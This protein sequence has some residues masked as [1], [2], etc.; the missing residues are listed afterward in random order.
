MLKNSDVIGLTRNVKKL[1]S[2]HMIYSAFLLVSSTFSSVTSSTFTYTCHKR[3]ALHFHPHADWHSRSVLSLD[4][5]LHLSV[6]CV[7]P[8]FF[9][10]H[11]VYNSRNL[12]LSAVLP[13]VGSSRTSRKAVVL[14]FSQKRFYQTKKSSWW[15]KKGNK[16][17]PTNQSTKKPPAHQNKKHKGSLCLPFVFD[18]CSSQR[19]PFL[20]R[21]AYFF[22]VFRKVCWHYPILIFPIVFFP[23]NVW[24][25]LQSVHISSNYSRDI[26]SNTVFS[27]SVCNIIIFWL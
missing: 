12:S 7:Y 23:F 24:G 3:T 19:L 14:L 1:Y 2:R 26:W 11:I 22:L 13:L 18:C 10:I 27:Q 25:T 8:S 4:L 15:G 20:S 9:S 5:L 21:F 6:S 17:T 16:K